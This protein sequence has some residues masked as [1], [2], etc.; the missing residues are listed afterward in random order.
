[1]T[2]NA[3]RIKFSKADGFEFT[4][5]DRTLYID[6]NGDLHDVRHVTPENDDE[7]DLGTAAL[8]FHDLYILLNQ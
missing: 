4:V 8:Q 6:A 5:D 1:M 2:L 7:S 3:A